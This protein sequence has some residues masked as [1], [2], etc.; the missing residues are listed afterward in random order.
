M[1]GRRQH[2]A[3]QG[4]EWKGSARA[5]APILFILAWASYPIAGVAATAPADSS[6]AGTAA[7][8]ASGCTQ[9][10][11]RQ[12]PA[13]AARRLSNWAWRGASWRLEQCWDPVS[14]QRRNGTGL[15]TLVG[16]PLSK[17]QA[18]AM[19]D[20]QGRERVCIAA[21]PRGLVANLGKHVAIGFGQT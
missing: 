4:L 1:C 21:P 11:V 19:F 16:I 17:G 3:G 10:C 5:R 9:P 15:W 7:A 14:E 18:H 12:L 8:S 2:V 13:K 20:D 6:V